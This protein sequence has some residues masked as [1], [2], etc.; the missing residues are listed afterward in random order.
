MDDLIILKWN[1]KNDRHCWQSV[2]GCHRG[3]LSMQTLA[4]ILW[5]SGLCG[6][7][8]IIFA[9]NSVMLEDWSRG[10]PMTDGDLFNQQM[11]D[12]LEK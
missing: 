12:I 9:N 5:K 8:Q 6:S 3:I 1:L 7:I 2:F 10:F 11:E 4:R